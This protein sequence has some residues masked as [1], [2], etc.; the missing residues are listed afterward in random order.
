MY[1]S[2]NS[3]VLI[4]IKILSFKHFYSSQIVHEKRHNSKKLYLVSGT[5]SGQ[6]HK[7]RKIAFENMTTSTNIIYIDKRLYLCSKIDVKKHTSSFIVQSNFS[8]YSKC[9]LSENHIRSQ[10]EKGKYLY[11]HQFFIRISVLQNILATDPVGYKMFFGSK[12]FFK[13]HFF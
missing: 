1:V 11:F 2:I 9:N 4:L 3:Y 12:T 8:R 13:T 5:T 10:N 6:N 7:K